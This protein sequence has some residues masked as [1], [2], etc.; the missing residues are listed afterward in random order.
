MR[1]IKFR[2][3]CKTSKQFCTNGFVESNL[4]NLLRIDDRDGGDYIVTQYTGL[5]DKNGKEIYE[6]DIVYYQ[7]DSYDK[8]NLWEVA[9]QSDMW[10]MKRGDRITGDMNCGD[11][12]H[13]N[14]WGE[15]EIKG[16]IY[17]NKELLK[18]EV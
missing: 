13:Y 15:A 12:P 17:E 18:E 6:G 11:D 3:W 2:A 16:N 9:W 4:F 7:Y 10:I 8:L 1:D 5:K 14:S